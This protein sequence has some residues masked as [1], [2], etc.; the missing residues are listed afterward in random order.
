MSAEIRDRPHRGK[1]VGAQ[2]SPVDVALC[3]QT[4]VSDGT[5]GMVSI[6]QLRVS[7]LCFLGF[8]LAGQ[9]ETLTGCIMKQVKSSTCSLN[10]CD[11]IY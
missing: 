4:G 8:S 10:I 7:D 1:A 6:R 2:L 9:C 11:L 3:C 5:M